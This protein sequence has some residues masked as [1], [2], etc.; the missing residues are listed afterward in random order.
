MKNFCNKAA[1][2]LEQ[3]IRS[4]WPITIVIKANEKRG[5]T[6]A[7]GC[8]GA[9]ESVSSFNEE[10]GVFTDMLGNAE[11]GEV[12]ASDMSAVGEETLFTSKVIN[13]AANTML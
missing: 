7:G 1:Q 10:I 2:A 12:L 6:N 13:N 3:I 4:A 8:T 11:V 9:L 5:L